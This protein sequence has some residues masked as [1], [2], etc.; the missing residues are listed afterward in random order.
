MTVEQAQ[1]LLQLFRLTPLSGIKNLTGVAS[2]E[3]NQ[4]TANWY[5]YPHEDPG[6]A[7]MK[8]LGVSHY[9]IREETLYMEPEAATKLKLLTG[10]YHHT[11]IKAWY[12]RHK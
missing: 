6:K 12:A 5:K 3:F 4:A 9:N 11:I 8:Y 1:M 7:F 2:N 10:P